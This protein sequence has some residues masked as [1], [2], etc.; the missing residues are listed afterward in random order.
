MHASLRSLSSRVEIVICF[1]TIL[2]RL[3][4][5][6]ECDLWFSSCSLSES[7]AIIECTIHVF[8]EIISAYTTV[9]NGKRSFSTSYLE[10]RREWRFFVSSRIGNQKSLFNMAVLR[11]FYIC[12]T[13][14]R[15]NLK[16]TKKTP[17]FTPVQHEIMLHRV[18][19]APSRR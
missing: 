17:N 4:R 7:Q 8:A 16:Y 18:L 2:S 12:L 14:L 19:R 15:E 6:S 5:E 9:Y 3:L 10:K 13:Y 1:F 11:K